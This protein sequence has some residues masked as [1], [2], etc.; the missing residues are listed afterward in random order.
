MEK[1]EHVEPL[2]VAYCL[3]CGAPATENRDPKT[4][5][6]VELSCPSDESHTTF[7]DERPN[8]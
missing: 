2:P 7:A 5:I 8:D 3:V 1:R 6:I 4:D